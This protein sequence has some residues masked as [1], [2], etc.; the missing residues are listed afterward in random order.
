MRINLNNVQGEW[1]PGV[2]ADV[3]D[4]IKG[5]FSVLLMTDTIDA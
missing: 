3:N 4:Q 2:E 1:P 5:W